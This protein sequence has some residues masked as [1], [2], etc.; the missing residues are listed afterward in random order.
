MAL[1]DGGCILNIDDITMIAKVKEFPA[2]ICFRYNPGERRTGN[3][4]IGIPVEAKYGLRHDQVIPA[5]RAA[6]KRGARRFGLHSMIISNERNY[7]YMVE[8]VH[9][10]LEVI[11]TVSRELNINF[12]FFNISGGMPTRVSIQRAKLEPAL[13]A[14]GVTAEAARRFMSALETA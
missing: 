8:T 12:E 6:I 4:L 14:L 3:Q 2:L 10:L 7:H 13:L 11:E 9:M 5:Y 1:S